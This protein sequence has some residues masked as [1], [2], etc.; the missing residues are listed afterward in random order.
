[1]MRRMIPLIAAFGLAA[2]QPAAEP[3]APMPVEEAARAAVPPPQAAVAPAAPATSPAKPAATPSRAAP[4]RPAG[5]AADT[6]APAPVRAPPPPSAPA[7]APMTDHSGHDMS[8]MP[9]A[10]KQ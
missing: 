5:R 10:P 3:A 6:P 4:A 2:C 1:M 9:A 7:P 8:T